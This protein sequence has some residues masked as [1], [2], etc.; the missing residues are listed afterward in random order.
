MPHACVPACVP[1]CARACLMPH[2]SCIMPHAC[3]RAC[4]PR[5]LRGP[6]VRRAVMCASN[7]Q[8]TG[9]KRV[10][11]GRLLHVRALSLSLACL[12]LLASCFLPRLKADRF[13]RAL[14]RIATQLST[15]ARTTTP[16]ARAQ[17]VVSRTAHRVR[18]RTPRLCK[19]GSITTAA[20][21]TATSYT[22]R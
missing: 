6:Q 10:G 15:S 1:A 18:T 22:S 20:I 11:M 21:S 17:T 16:A 13:V 3:L 2:A 12:L 8:R 19:A 14:A 9:E 5:A 4:L 7:E